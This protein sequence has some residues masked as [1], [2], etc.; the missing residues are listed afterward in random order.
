MQVLVVE[1]LLELLLELELLELELLELLELELLLELL[2]L[3]LLELSATVV[4][5]S[6]EEL[7]VE[8]VSPVVGDVD[9]LGS[10][11]ASESSAVDAEPSV[12]EE[13]DD[14]DDAPPDIVSAAVAEIPVVGDVDEVGVSSVSAVESDVP[15]AL[16][17]VV[18][19]APG[20]LHA[21]T[22]ATPSTDAHR[23]DF[24]AKFES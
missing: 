7:V 8:S 9:E 18:V 24:I 13:D 21:A 20:S 4:P 3:L 17:K 6:L 22:K 16:S 10:E 12:T 23:I 11:D 2:E 14:D 5:S 19:N 15:L 1:L